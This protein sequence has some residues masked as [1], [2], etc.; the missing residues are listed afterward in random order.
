M[1]F[2]I[3]SHLINMPYSTLWMLDFF[4]NSTIRVS[5][6]LDPDPAQHFVGPDLG[7][8][9]YK[10]FSRRQNL[11]LVGKELDTNNLLIKL[12]S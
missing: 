1:A 6:S 9:V 12:S 10:G 4:S 2:I 3:P 8:T 7:P 5:N 11:L